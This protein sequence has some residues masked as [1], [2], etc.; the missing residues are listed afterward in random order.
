ME[1]GENI[2]APSKSNFF[3]WLSS[4]IFWSRCHGHLINFKILKKNRPCILLTM[5]ST[6]TDFVDFVALDD[7]HHGV[8][9]VGIIWHDSTPSD[10]FEKHGNNMKSALNEKEMMPKRQVCLD[11]ILTVVEVQAAMGLYLSRIHAPR[12]ML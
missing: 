6:L 1:T 4:L 3:V 9:T 11:E 12:T 8:A 7:T 10:S 5:R 2:T